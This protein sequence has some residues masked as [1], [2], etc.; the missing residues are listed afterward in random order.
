MLLHHD[1]KELSRDATTR[2]GYEMRSTAT[3]GNLNFFEPSN[4]DR[5]S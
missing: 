2:K 5:V 3:V 1:R 4:R